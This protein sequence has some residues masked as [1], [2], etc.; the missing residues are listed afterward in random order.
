MGLKIVKKSRI[1]VGKCRNKKTNLRHFKS[2]AH[3][4]FV[5]FFNF[6]ALLILRQQFWQNSPSFG[7]ATFAEF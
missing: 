3:L 2:C 7:T 4:K 6:A 1:K 5:T